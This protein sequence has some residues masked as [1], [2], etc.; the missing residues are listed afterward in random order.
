MIV[1]ITSC[2]VFNPSEIF[3]GIAFQA[4][5]LVQY[6]FKYAVMI[7]VMRI[8]DFN[9]ILRIKNLLFRSGCLTAKC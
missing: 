8:I 5:R 6:S 3:L 2:F 7:L 4:G 9:S 1:Y